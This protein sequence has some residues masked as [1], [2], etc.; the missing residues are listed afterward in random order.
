MILPTKKTLAGI[1][2]SASA[3]F[4][5]RAPGR[6]PHWAARAGKRWSALSTR[7]S[8]R[9]FI[10]HL[11]PTRSSPYTWWPM[12][13]DIL[14][15]AVP[16]SHVI[17]TPMVTT[18]KLTALHDQRMFGGPGNFE[19]IRE[20]NVFNDSTVFRRGGC[21]HISFGRIA[22]LLRNTSCMERRRLHV[23]QDIK[24]F[25]IK[26]SEGTASHSSPAGSR[27]AV[28]RFLQSLSL[29]TPHFNFQRNILAGHHQALGGPLCSTLLRAGKERVGSIL[30]VFDYLAFA[31]PLVRACRGPTR[32]RS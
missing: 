7:Y 24:Q 19:I 1:L 10:C 16:A 26:R 28:C 23:W 6:L 20:D 31:K 21:R 27:T 4:L 9:H 32:R 29:L 13:A 14:D 17:A 18:R 3:I 11:S 2:R 22:L 15:R 30:S 12:A 5:M 25:S 8:W